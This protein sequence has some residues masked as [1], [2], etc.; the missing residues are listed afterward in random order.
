[1]SR[2]SADLDA[3]R[4]TIH[5]V[6]RLLG[7]THVRD[8]QHRLGALGSNS[9]NL[10]RALLENALSWETEKSDDEEETASGRD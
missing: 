7:D 10:A 1:M 4:E 2:S 6:A 8:N 5:A 9:I 3:Y